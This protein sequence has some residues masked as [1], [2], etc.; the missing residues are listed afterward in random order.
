MNIF[1]QGMLTGLAIGLVMLAGDYMV[2][3]KLARERAVRQHKTVA[4]FDGTEKAR[5]RSLAMF[6]VILPPIFGVFFWMIW[7]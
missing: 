2:L 5:I 4:E 6:C 1:F 7:G 3:R